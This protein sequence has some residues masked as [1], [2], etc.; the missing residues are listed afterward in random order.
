M[1]NWTFLLFVCL[2]PLS[3]FV[4][5]AWTGD[6]DDPKVRIEEV[7]SIGQLDD[8][9][10]F[11][12]AAV[13]ADEE[14][15]IYLTDSMDYSLKKFDDRGFFLARA[16]RRGQGP[17]EFTAPRLLV[18]RKDFLYVTDQ[19]KPGIQVF[20]KKLEYQTSIPILSAIFDLEVITADRLA[21]ATLNLKASPAIIIYD[22]RG[23][24]VRKI[25]YS[26]ESLGFMM[27]LVSFTLDASG[28]VF[29]AFTYS[30]RIQ[31]FDSQGREIWSIK[32][33]E[34]KK[35]KRKKVAGF[36]VPAHM[37]NKDLTLD[38]RGNLY[39]LGGALASSP[40]REVFVIDPTGKLVTSFVLPDTTHC[41]YMD[42]RDYLYSR[43][44]DGI[45]LKIYRLSF[46]ID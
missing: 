8:D 20:D 24:I 12:W 2:V 21:V 41:I 6:K 35:S 43:A 44:N 17:G 7:L 19:N 39:V 3:G 26:K 42:G 29:I 32:L 34:G 1:R 11:Q 30:D 27:D 45:T 4:S 33:F 22:S 37:V 25:L 38:S 40:S 5:L 36:D 9:S 23:K 18:Y 28:S 10:L 46:V 15:H 16:G 13:A 31:K 14:G